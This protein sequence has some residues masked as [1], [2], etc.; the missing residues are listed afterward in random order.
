MIKAV[1]FDMD[2]LMFDTEVL[3]GRFWIQAA[4][5]H[6]FDMKPEHTVAIRSMH[7]RFSEP[8]LKRQLGED[9]DYRAVRGRRIE[10]MNTYL[11]ENGIP[12]KKGLDE[13]L[14][15]LGSRG[16]KRAVC[17]ATDQER[18]RGYLARAGVADSF[19]KLICGDMIKIGKPAP[20]IYS[21]A[22]EQLGLD[23]AECMALEDSPNGIISAAAA[24]L[25]VVMI[26]DRSQPS[27]DIMPLLLAVCPSL[28]KVAEL[29]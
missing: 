15:F 11:S 20:Y 18:T 4:R 25:N 26:P 21:F 3:L 19:D 10:L 5:E 24:G 6:G 14:G 22:C 23:P 9:F 28:D 29:F 1:L 2:G 17:T 12:K 7:R 13:L 27:E 8:Y 16:I